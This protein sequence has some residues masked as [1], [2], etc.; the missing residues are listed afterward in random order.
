M[1][2]KTWVGGGGRADLGDVYRASSECREDEP[3]C[4]KFRCREAQEFGGWS[5]CH[6]VVMNEFL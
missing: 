3:L 1:R 2:R 4:E 6:Y 5:G